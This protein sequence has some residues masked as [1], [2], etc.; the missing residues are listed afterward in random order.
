MDTKSGFAFVVS[1]IDV[2]G[3]LPVE[4]IPDHN[5][6]RAADSEIESIRQLLNASIPPH[7]TGY[8]PRY[9]SVV[10][11]ERYEGS[12][13]YHFDELPAEKWKYWVIAFEGNNIRV[14]QLEVPLLLLE[15]EIELGF[16]VYFTKS[17]QQGDQI[18]WSMI[19]LHLVEKYAHPGA[20]YKNAR[21]ITVDELQRIGQYFDL[22]NSIPEQFPFLDHALKNF[23][24][25]R[26]ISSRSE[27][28]A[29]GYFS[30]IEALVTHPPRLAETLDSIGHQIRTKISLM[31]KRFQNPLNY[32]EYFLP[33]TE[34]TIWMKLYS[35]R[36]ALAHGTIPKF[37]SEL[38]ILRDHDT[39]VR[40]LKGTVKQLL[41]S[42]LHDPEFL[43]D[44]KQC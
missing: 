26:R 20:A 8:W 39:V 10:R 18:G 4:L 3:N 19:P 2:Q 23:S 32:A 44:L 34:E 38:Q 40:F 24:S 1:H 7:F 9:D 5:F 25:I 41:L 27:L 42:G 14:H 30:I 21:T 17:A 28:I 43:S 31:N 13:S 11:E 35:Y 12:S 37:E 6:R 22:C 15:P 29:V 33:S 16:Q 36:S